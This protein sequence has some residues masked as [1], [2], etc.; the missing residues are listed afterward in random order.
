MGAVASGF[1]GVAIEWREP[2][3]RHGSAC[4][5]RA[6]V[7]PCRLRQIEE[8]VEHPRAELERINGNALIDTV[9]EV[10]KRQ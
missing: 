6:V 2:P 8:P 3:R 4:T 9:K 1:V 5:D 7:Q 10:G